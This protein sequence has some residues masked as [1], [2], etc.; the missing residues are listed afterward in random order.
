[1]P[2]PLGERIFARMNRLTLGLT[3]TQ[4]AAVLAVFVVTLVGAIML[5]LLFRRWNEAQ[6][7]LSGDETS[8]D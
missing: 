5:T 3:S 1:L 8:S 7:V 2:S 6:A 4:I